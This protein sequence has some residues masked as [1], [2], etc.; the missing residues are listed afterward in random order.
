[1]N[2]SI[3]MPGDKDFHGPVSHDH[4][5]DPQEAPK[6]PS[7]VLEAAFSEVVDE[8][9][10]N[11]EAKPEEVPGEKKEP[12]PPKASYKFHR[13]AR[14]KS[15]KVPMPQHMTVTL[16]EDLPRSWEKKCHVGGIDYVAV[17]GH[18]FKER[19]RKPGFKTGEKITLTE[20]YFYPGVG[21]L[22]AFT[23]GNRAGLAVR[24][25]QFVFDPVVPQSKVD[26]A[27]VSE[28][29][30]P[31]EEQQNDTGIGRQEG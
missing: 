11:L 27:S 22:Y 29:L 14:Q 17:P 24:Q 5:Y 26:V 8:V 2:K 30:T 28:N 15:F 21:A 18:E 25:D 6:L 1:M 23:E 3:I 20:M 10:A 19:I 9:K 12:D 31:I 13:P 7:E 4:E 16:T